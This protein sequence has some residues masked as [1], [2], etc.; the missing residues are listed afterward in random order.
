MRII[1]TYQALLPAVAL[2]SASLVRAQSDQP[3]SQPGFGSLFH[4]MN[5]LPE[6]VDQNLPF[7]EPGGTYWFY[8]HPHFGNPFQGKYF[9]LDAGGWLK[10]TDNLDFNLGAQS[11]FWRDPNS[12][13]S[14]RLGFYGVNT[15]VKYSESLLSPPGAAMSFGINYSSP[16]GRP[17]ISLVDGYRHTDPF[18]TYSRPLIPS[19]SLVGYSSLGLDLLAHSPLPG[20]FGVNE[21]HSNSITFSAGVSRQWPRFTG[22]VTL[23][24]ATSELISKEGRQVFTLNPEV[25]IPIFRQR[26]PRWH[27]RLAIGAHVTDGPDGRQIGASASINI[28]FK[29][30]P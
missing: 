6:L 17:P 4:F 23:T 8:G 7:M 28:N 12:D 27:A 2:I 18:V 21:L 14:T 11:Y 1:P 26:L 30:R 20:N 9:R 29:S 15:G 16:V 10:A 19:L 13:N 5:T 25:F 3:V 22:S 24:G